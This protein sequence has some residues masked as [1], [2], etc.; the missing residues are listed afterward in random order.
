MIDKFI[1]NIDLFFME[2]LTSDY[3]KVGY[4]VDLKDQLG[5][6]VIGRI[7]SIDPEEGFVKIKIY[8]S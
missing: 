8:M 7:V 5:N 1:V 3:I 4:F 6:W 2:N